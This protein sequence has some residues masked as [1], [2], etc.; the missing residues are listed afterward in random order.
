MCLVSLCSRLPS[1]ELATCHT[2]DGKFMKA[3]LVLGAHLY[4][5]AGFPSNHA[6]HFLVTLALHWRSI[7][8]DELSPVSKARFV[9][10]SF[11]VDHTDIQDSWIT[12]ALGSN[13]K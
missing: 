7:N 13:M 6:D 11:R 10:W 12:D 4:D 5:G 8:T 2:F 3:F 1:W 9:R